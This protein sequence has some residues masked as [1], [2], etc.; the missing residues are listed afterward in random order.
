MADPAGGGLGVEIVY[1]LGFAACNVAHL[2]QVW[3]HVSLLYPSTNLSTLQTR[4]I[5][6]LGV[7]DHGRSRASSLL[8]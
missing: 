2:V 1:L 8:A 6:G 5:A 4:Y 3:A 7:I